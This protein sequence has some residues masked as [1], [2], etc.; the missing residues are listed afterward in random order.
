MNVGEAIREAAARL[1]ATSDTA[2]L[3]AELLMAHALGTDRSAMLLRAMTEPAPVEFGALVERRMHREPVAYIL[4]EAEFYGRSFAVRP[5]LLI[6]RG[7]SETVVDAALDLLG[8]EG[9]VLDLGTG[10][11]AL[12]LTILAERPAMTGV[13]IDASLAAL[14]VASLNAARL[15]L[16]DRAQI[17]RGDWGEAG[18]AEDLGRF[19][20]V[21]SNPPYVETG[22]VLDPDVREYEPSSALFAGKEGLDDYR[23]IIPQLGKLLVPGGAAVLEIGHEQ[24]LAVGAIARDSGFDVA[25]RQDLGGRD[26]ALLLT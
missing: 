17:L 23:A 8:N 22:A 1:S 12:L 20:L 3:D 5:G 18:W 19:D 21:I 7:D 10:S 11:G 2:R 13:G 15:D 14:P 26:R 16:E 9:R 24:A 4:G 25:V 6:P